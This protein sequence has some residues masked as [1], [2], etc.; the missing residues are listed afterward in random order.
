MQEEASDEPYSA[1]PSFNHRTRPDTV[2]FTAGGVF[3][4][5]LAT[6]YTCTRDNQSR[7]HPRP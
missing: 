1:G 7:R 2:I 5:S 4:R 6:T 3:G